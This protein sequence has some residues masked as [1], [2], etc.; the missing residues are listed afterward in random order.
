M[1]AWSA[2]HAVTA[3]ARNYYCKLPPL[4]GRRVLVVDP[5]LASGG[6]ASQAIEVVKQN[7][8]VAPRLVCIIAAPEGVAEVARHHPDA[9]VHVGVL[10]RA[11]NSRKYILPGL[12]DFGD[13]LYGT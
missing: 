8:A 13:R 7:G 6:S 4:Q 5:M 10:D 1:W 12:G 2:H 9:S 3:V 11:L